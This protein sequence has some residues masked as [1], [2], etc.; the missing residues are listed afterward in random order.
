[1]LRFP[2]K[3]LNSSK[4]THPSLWSFFF[5]QWYQMAHFCV[6]A[7][8][9]DAPISC[10]SSFITPESHIE[11]NF[12]NSLYTISFTNLNMSKFERKTVSLCLQEYVILRLQISLVLSF[13]KMGGAGIY[14]KF[15]IDWIESSP[16]I[17]I[18]STHFRTKFEMLLGEIFKK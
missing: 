13:M 10:L 6:F 1:M 16:D 11:D 8:K 2:Q 17:L 18:F 12:N 9:V 3:G 14:F 15:I 5:N 7:L 4:I